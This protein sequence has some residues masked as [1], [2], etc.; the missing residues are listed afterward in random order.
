MKNRI[1]IFAFLLSSSAHAYIPESLVSSG[2]VFPSPTDSV[3]YNASTL[4]FISR[5]HAEIVLGTPLGKGEPIRGIAALRGRAGEA[6]IGAAVEY[7][8]PLLVLRGGLGFPFSLWSGKAALG[9]SLTYYK[10]EA[11]E[12]AGGDGTGSSDGGSDGGSGMTVPGASAPSTIDANISGTWQRNQF[13]A[14]FILH[15]IR[16][17]FPIITGGIGV[18]SDSL[19]MEFDTEWVRNNYNDIFFTPGIGFMSGPWSGA[20]RHYFSFIDEGTPAGRTLEAGSLSAGL[21]Y[22]VNYQSSWRVLY[23]YDPNTWNIGY[24]RR[25]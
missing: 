3:R 22:Q 16:D 9:A 6:G 13:R 20:V 15:S 7:W 18:R 12:G 19:F 14:S 2:M 17:S 4:P 10:E 23:Q 11:W 21:G 24:L 8:N 1:W 5:S 25:F